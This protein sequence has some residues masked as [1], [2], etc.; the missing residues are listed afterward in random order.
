MI[1]FWRAPRDRWGAGEI[2]VIIEKV[3]ELERLGLISRVNAEFA[4]PAFLVKQK[5]VFRLVIDYRPLTR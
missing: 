1:G 4:S 5:G 3:T 2:P